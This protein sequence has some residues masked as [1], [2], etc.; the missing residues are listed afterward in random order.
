MFTFNDSGNNIFE[1][2][3]ILISPL[4][5]NVITF[6]LFLFFS[7]KDYAKKVVNL[8]NAL[9]SLSQI[10]FSDYLCDDF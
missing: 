10:Y 6:A 3:N 2:S 9:F 1:H 7:Y 8:K 4:R 5:A